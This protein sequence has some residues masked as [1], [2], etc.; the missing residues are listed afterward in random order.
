MGEPMYGRTFRNFLIAL[1]TV[2]L[3]AHAAAPT[4]LSANAGE[5]RDIV[6]VSATVGYAGTVG[7]GIWKTSDAGANW[8]KLSLPVKTVWKV[9]VSPATT[10]NLFAATSEG[11]WRS[12]DAGATWNQLTLDPTRAIAVQPGSAAGSE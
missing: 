7:G 4:K 10:N 3:S 6:V 5:V 12:T 2:G 11:V 8:A 1:A 9:A